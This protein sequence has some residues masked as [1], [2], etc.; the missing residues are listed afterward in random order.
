MSGRDEQAVGPW[1]GA[2]P[3]TGLAALV[4]IPLPG[5]RG[6]AIEFTPRNFKG[7]STSTLFI[8]DLAG[9]RVLRL[10]HGYNVR[11]KTIDY[12]WNQKGTFAD[13]GIADHTSV[14]RAGA[15]LYRFSKGFRYGGRVLVVVGVALDAASIV[16]SNRPLRRS[17]QVV[18][19]WAA[20][21]AGAEAAGAVGA[22]A[23]TL[24]EP[25]GGTAV[26]GIVFAIGG[27]IVGYW[28]GEKAGALVYDWGDAVFHPL[29]SAPVDGHR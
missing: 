11:T 4:R 24:L 10:D 2:V 22:A 8:Q 18:S 13:F 20:A 23:G 28:A 19:A 5:S 12:H 16:E 29:P 6:L 7:Q 21:W 9:K 15:A 17:T 14:G 27:G 1:T 3:A 26:F 25:G